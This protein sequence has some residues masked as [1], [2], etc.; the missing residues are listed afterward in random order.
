MPVPCEIGVCARKPPHTQPP[1]LTRP[2]MC[3]KTPKTRYTAAVACVGAA[4][5]AAAPA[6][7]PQTSGVA[8]R[9]RG[10][11]AASDHVAWASG[12]NGTILRTTDGGA[13]WRH[14]GPPNTG[15]LDFRD[16]DAV[17]R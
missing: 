7:T 13:T 17:S 4:V 16:I 15:A 1:S 12:A 2:V 8:A 5:L 9:L 6:W 3:F 11:S 14:V 10:V